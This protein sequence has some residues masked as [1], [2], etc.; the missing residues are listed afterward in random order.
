[1]SIESAISLSE[2]HASPARSHALTLTIV[3]VKGLPG[4]VMATYK[5]MPAP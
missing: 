3:Y 5:K 4:G 1:M 2:V